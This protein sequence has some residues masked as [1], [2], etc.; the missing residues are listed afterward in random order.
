MIYHGE[1]YDITIKYS[2]GQSGFYVTYLVFSDL[3]KTISMFVAAWLDGFFFCIW[4]S[5]MDEKY[6]LLPEVSDTVH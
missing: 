1:D 2:S 5:W 4:Y 3:T 6:Q